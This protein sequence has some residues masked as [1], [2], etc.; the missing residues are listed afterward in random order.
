MVWSFSCHGFMQRIEIR[1]DHILAKY[2][3]VLSR[4]H[5]TFV[6]CSISIVFA[7]D[8]VACSLPYAGLNR[9]RCCRGCDLSQP[10]VCGKH[11]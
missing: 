8:D 4:A 11:P 2:E 1:H 7:W 10:P 6:L 5:L 9:F 3:R